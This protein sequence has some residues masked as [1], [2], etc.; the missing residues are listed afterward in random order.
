MGQQEKLE[1]KM[2]ICQA[3]DGQPPL[4]I[5]RLAQ[6][7]GVSGRD[8]TDALVELE[9]VGAVVS[10]PKGGKM[11]YSLASAKPVSDKKPT[12][13]NEKEMRENV[14]RYFKGRPGQDVS[15]R[16]INAML[17]SY[18]AG[19]SVLNKL[20]EDGLIERSGHGIWRLV[21]GLPENQDGGQSVTP[22]TVVL[23]EM[24]TEPA[25]QPQPKE[26]DTV[27]LTAANADEKPSD[28]HDIKIGGFSDGS[29]SIDKGNGLWKMQLSR[30]QMLKVVGF[31]EKFIAMEGV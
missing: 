23:A 15:T 22:Q 24:A 8:L 1:N 19:T 18:Q 14:L 25:V 12:G 5:E 27:V 6:L 21:G 26:D 30:G 16:S 7:S 3:M 29:F 17:G 20:K 2:A 13:K 9:G 4:R 11:V 28:E 31:V 10:T